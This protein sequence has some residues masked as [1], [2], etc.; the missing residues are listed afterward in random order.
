VIRY[1]V[2]LRV[3]VVID[4]GMSCLDRFSAYSMITI[5]IILIEML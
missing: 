4:Y 3:F 1:F 5:Y 2:G